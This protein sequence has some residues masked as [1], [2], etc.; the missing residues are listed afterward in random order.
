MH[1]TAKFAF[2]ALGLAPTVLGAK[3]IASHY[4]GAVFTLD[5]KLDGGVSTLSSQ[6]KVDGCGQLPGWLEYYPEDKTLYCFDESWYGSGLI[7]SYNVSDDGSL[8]L[9]GQTP[10]TGND[11]H[12]LLYGGP[13][14]KSFVAT[15][16]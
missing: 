4:T 10:T 6:A 1:S 16:Q 11:V 15:A 7:A 13:K 3:L 9:F 8:K 5:L 12:G 2:A 14:G